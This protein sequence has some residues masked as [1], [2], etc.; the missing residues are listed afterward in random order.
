MTTAEA[1]STMT[2]VEAS[3]A[4]LDDAMAADPSVFLL[5]EDIADPQG[6]GAFKV[7][8]GLSE[9]YGLDRVRT[10]PISEQA[11]L[12]AAVGAAIA[13]K[14][15]VAEIMLMNFMA[16]CMDQLFNHAAKL[17]YMSGGQTTVPLTVRT[18]TGAAGGF[19]AQHSDML[20]AWLAHSAGL[21]VVMPSTPADAYGLL[22]GCINDD[23]P[24]VIIEHT[25]LYFTGA[26][27]EAPHRGASIPLSQANIARLGSDVTIISY[28]RMMHEVLAAATALAADGIEA[29]VIDLRTIAPWDQQTVLASAAKTKRAIV[30]HEAVTNFG[31]GAEVSSRI[32]EELFGELHAPVKRIG[33]AFCPVPFA[34]PLEQAFLCGQADI[35]AGVRALV[36]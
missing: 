3:R 1:T 16:V 14:R 33:S 13:G 9:T 34:A 20:E 2:F 25:G 26:Q 10:T 21:K 35:E 32:H 15:P 36:S 12:G 23:D 6:G 31:V 8:M 18:A 22:L 28:G 5:G 30:V 19:A 4:A 17:R 7:T 27:G 24:C 29:E 11:I